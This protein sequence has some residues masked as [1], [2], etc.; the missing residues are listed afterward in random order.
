LKQIELEKKSSTLFNIPVNVEKK[1]FR[2]LH[3]TH[4]HPL[5]TIKIL[6]ENYFK[7]EWAKKNGILLSSVSL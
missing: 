6:I 7:D 3:N 4:G 2:N 1:L 5:A